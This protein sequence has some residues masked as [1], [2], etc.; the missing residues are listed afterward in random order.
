MALSR[1]ARALLDTGA[2]SPARDAAQ[3]AVADAVA[4][5]RR[6]DLVGLPTE[7]VYGLAADA[8]QAAA[9]AKVFAAKE[10]PADH[11]LIVHVAGA[12]PQQWRTAVE[13]Y[14]HSV[15]DFAW[16]LM[17]AFWP[18]PLTVILPRRPEVGALRPA[19][20]TRSAC[21]ARRTQS[22]KPCCKRASTPASTVSPRPAP[23]GSGVSA[24]PRRPMCTTNSMIA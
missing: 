23:T 14:A 7:T 6:G 24:R 19:G 10:R 4:T 12:T 5:L 9:V 2:S 11:P 15:P 17:E 22:P 8:D 3:A 21:A 20:R 18:G 1:D 16:A 13:H